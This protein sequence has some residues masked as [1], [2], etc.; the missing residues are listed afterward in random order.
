[1]LGPE[2][3]RARRRSSGW[4]P[5][6]SAR[7]MCANAYQS[8]SVA[9]PRRDRA[10]AA[11]SGSS[12]VAGRVHVAGAPS[13]TPTNSAAARKRRERRASLGAA[14]FVHELDAVDAHD[15]VV[16]EVGSAEAARR[17]P[18]ADVSVDA[19]PAGAST[20]SATACSAS[21]VAGNGR[22][23]AARARARRNRS[24]PSLRCRHYPGPMATVDDLLAARAPRL[25]RVAPAEAAARHAAGALLIDVRLDD[26]R[27]ARRH[28]SRVPSCSR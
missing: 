17:R 20:C 2:L 14:L 10:R 9:R 26:E 15:L 23:A 12:A 6:I 21:R 7:R 22:R 24:R 5:Q 27:A 8:A 11:A 18:Q 4:S 19:I 1:M 25:A 13:G 28:H 3:P 16:A